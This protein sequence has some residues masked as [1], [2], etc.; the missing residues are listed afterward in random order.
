MLEVEEEVRR[1][2]LGNTDKVDRMQVELKERDELVGKLRRELD[3]EGKRYRREVEG[4][5]R[6]VQMLYKRVQEIETRQF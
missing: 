6:E 1:Y 4:R 3:E 2:A 5:D